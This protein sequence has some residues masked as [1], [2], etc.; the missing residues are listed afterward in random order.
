MLCHQCGGRLEGDFTVCPFC[1]VHQS[2]DL[3][4]IHFRDLGPSPLLPC[5]CCKTPLH[6]LKTGS[7]PDTHLERCPSCHGM[8]FNPGELEAVLHDNT[9]DDIWLDSVRLTAI[10]DNLPDPPAEVTYRKCPHCRDIMT[11]IN[12]GGRSGVIIDRCIK[13]GVWLDHGE[14]H[15]LLQWWHAGGKW[16]YKNHLTQTATQPTPQ[17]TPLYESGPPT[18][19]VGNDD[20]FDK[21]DTIKLIAGV[22]LLLLRFLK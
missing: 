3:R 22:A 14:L 20:I 5:P 17:Y 12:F 7:D 16:I 10:K 8:F 2:I 21:W 4:E 15:H 19:Y 1:G 11:R 6:T 18:P 9:T 13:H